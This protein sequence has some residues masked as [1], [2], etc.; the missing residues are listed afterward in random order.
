MTL[1]LKAQLALAGLWSLAVIGA[2]IAQIIW[3]TRPVA[4]QGDAAA[5]E[6]HLTETLTQGAGHQFGSATAALIQG[7]SVKVASGFGS[8]TPS[9]EPPDP[10]ETLYQMASVSKLVTT[11]GVM[12]LV[13]DGAIDLDAPASTYLSRWQFPASEFDTEA[14]TVRRLLS[15]TAGLGDGFG[16]AGFLP[17]EPLQTLE[18]SLTRTQDPV[19][20]EPRGVTVT[21]PPGK[22]LRYSGGG[23]TVLQLLIEEVSGLPFAD[24]MNQ[25]VLQPLGM[26]A[27]SFDWRQAEGRGTLATN[28]NTDLNPSPHRR[29]TAAA[30]ASLY[31][32]TQDMAILVQ[33]YSGNPVLDPATVA[34][35][36]APQPDTADIFGLGHLLYVKTAAGGYVVG[37]DGLNLPALNHMVRVNPATGNGI[38]VMVSGSQTLA[39]QLGDDWVYW[40]TGK[41]TADALVRQGLARL[42]LIGVAIALGIA[43]IIGLPQAIQIFAKA[44]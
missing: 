26:S 28:Y 24:Y 3:F 25:A 21:Q 6:A 33:A 36:T 20:G 1:S 37:H 14:I 7:G 8:A 38:V 44:T 17:D 41:R 11:W 34:Q 32:T 22:G 4:P 2:A 12:T 29:Y 39:S 16:Y 43:V 18:E 23:Y 42:P 30:A 27:S 10:E 40:E 15:H 19:T 9:G 5:F 31:A 13:R 35:M